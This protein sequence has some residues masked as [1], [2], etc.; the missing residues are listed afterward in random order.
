M[1]MVRNSH[2]A[3]EMISGSDCGHDH[4]LLDVKDAVSG[5]DTWLHRD[6]HAG[7][8]DRDVLLGHVEGVR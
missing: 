6:H 7:F 2:G 3:T 8:K 1:G 5:S 4:V